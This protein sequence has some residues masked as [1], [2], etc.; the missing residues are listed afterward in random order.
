MDK[1]IQSDWIHNTPSMP[2][3]LDKTQLFDLFKKIQSQQDVKNK[4]KEKALERMKKLE[5]MRLERL[6]FLD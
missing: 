1:I 4:R 5:Q 3:V 6:E 2:T